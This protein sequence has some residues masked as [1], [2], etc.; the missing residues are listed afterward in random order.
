MY[1]QISTISPPSHLGRA[2]RWSV[3]R[4]AKGMHYQ[5]PFSVLEKHNLHLS[6]VV[7]QGRHRKKG[8]SF[9]HNMALVTT[10][11]GECLSQN[12]SDT[13]TGSTRLRLIKGTCFTLSVPE[14]ARNRG[15]GKS[16]SQDAERT[17]PGT[18]WHKDGMGERMVTGRDKGQSA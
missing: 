7:T 5:G 1:T 11:G 15:E 14:S 8:S 12:N 2:G 9:P 13:I 16:T 18:T 10:K 4:S 17:K 3:F 6:C